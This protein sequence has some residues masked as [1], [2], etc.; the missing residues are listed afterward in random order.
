MPVALI[1]G[2][3]RG[4]GRALCVELGRRGWHLIVDARNRTPLDQ[5][6]HE[7]GNVDRVT[8]LTG[9]VS[10]PTHRE[11]LAGAVRERG[12]LDLLVNNAS[13]LGPTP[14]P[15]IATYPLEELEQV[16]RIN[17]IAP[18]ALIQTLL[19]QLAERSGTIINITSDAAVEAY[20][21]WGG[22]GASKAALDRL[23]AVLAAEEHAVR[24]YAFDPGDMR[25]E[26]QQEAFPGEDI[27]DRAEPE[28]VV[29]ALVRLIEQRPP[30]GRYRESDLR[31]AAGVRS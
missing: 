4:L 5:A 2:A 24:V 8:A 18:L 23:S 13:T 3:S 15:G 20:E 21:G 7:F 30:S 28:T 25:T 17:T 26:M 22:Y 29:P 31:V 27:S 1:T 12:S 16:L 19:P 6:V 10:D 9:D 11:E 14:L